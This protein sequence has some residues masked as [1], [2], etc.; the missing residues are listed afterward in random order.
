MSARFAVGDSVR[1][2]LAYPAGHCRT[3]YYCRGK[4]GV[5]VRYCGDFGNPEALAYGG[6]DGPEVPMYRIRFNQTDM[7][8]GYAGAPEDKVEIEIFEHWLVPTDM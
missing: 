7:W 3:P 5:V 2:R 6:Y 4:T 1:V 8:P